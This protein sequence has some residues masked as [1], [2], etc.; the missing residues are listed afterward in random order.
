M[1]G[2][3]S[4]KIQKTARYAISGDISKPV[5]HVWIICHGYGH[6][7]SYFI[8]K[9]DCLSEEGV[10]LIAPEGLH[11]FYLNGVN[12]RVGASWMTKE[13][14][15]SDIE[16]YIA[17]LD[18]VYE[19]LIPSLSPAPSTVNVL[20][21]SQGGATVSRWL[22]KTKKKVDTMTLWASVFPPDMDKNTDT[23]RLK[24]L[25]AFIVIGNK[26]EYISEEQK[27][28]HLAELTGMGI[29][30]MFSS[31]DGGHE[32]D[33]AALDKLKEAVYAAGKPQ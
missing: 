20:G 18:Q 21:F 19:V 16:D 33:E 15:L 6:L 30:Y 25:A 11:R 8:K 31:F 9:F 12:G 32:I 14:R 5:K 23:E 4:I 17:F 22:A 28:K 2:V 24:A 29:N 7:A 1:N 10:L 27:N 13:E 3:K 26:D